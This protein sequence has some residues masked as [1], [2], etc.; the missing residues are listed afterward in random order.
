MT[1]A[2]TSRRDVGRGSSYTDMRR[3]EH[4]RLHDVAAFESSHFLHVRPL[5]IL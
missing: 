3:R 4:F 1:A 5:R 2:A